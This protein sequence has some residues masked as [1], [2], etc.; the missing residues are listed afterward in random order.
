MKRS[1]AIKVFQALGDPHR[2]AIVEHLMKA[3]RSVQELAD[4]LP[5]SRPAVSRHLRVLKANHFVLDEARG[6]QR[7][8][9][10]RPES[11]EM[12]RDYFERLWDEARQ[13]F[14]IAAENTK[15]GDDN[16]A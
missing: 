8:Y 4:K 10:L 5:I 16:S 15:P 1:A 12:L 3:P 14:V 7:I 13:R 11:L 6:A 9:R 2:F